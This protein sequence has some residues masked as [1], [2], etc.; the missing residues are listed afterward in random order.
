MTYLA[1]CQSPVGQ[2]HLASDGGAITGLWISGQKYFAAALE[3]NAAEQDLPVF[4]QAVNWLDAYFSKSP[5]PALPP[6]APQGTPFRQAVWAMLQEIPYGQITTYGELARRLRERGISA[7]AQAVGGA[8]GHNPV[9][10]LIPCHRVVGS[11]GS[12][13]GYAGGLANKQ[14]LLELEGVDMHGLYVPKRGTAL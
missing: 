5:L 10:I 11:D 12:L 13:T 1:V 7:A 4:H 3:K 14:F 9:S 8:V 6:L 2:L